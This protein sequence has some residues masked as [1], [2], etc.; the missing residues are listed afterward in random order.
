MVKKT[1]G[2]NTLGDNNK[3]KVAIRDYERSTHNLSYVWRNKTIAVI[4]DKETGVIKSIET[5][6][7]ISQKELESEMRW[8]CMEAIKR[9]INKKKYKIININTY[10]YD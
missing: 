1:I 8:E 5:E 6:V 4:A 10:F 9:L 7:I 2:K 3:M